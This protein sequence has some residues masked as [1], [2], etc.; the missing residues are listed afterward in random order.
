MNKTPENDPDL[1]T[2]R[3]TIDR[4]A[5]ATYSPE[6]TRRIMEAVKAEAGVRR[7]PRFY[8]FIAAALVLLVLLLVLPLFMP[9]AGEKPADP[10]LERLLAAQQADGFWLPDPP[11]PAAYA[12]G[13]TAL[14]LLRLNTGAEATRF[15]VE[16]AQRALLAIQ[17]PNGSFAGAY[18]HAL[19]TYALLIRH[20]GGDATL[21]A[22]LDR[23]LAAL[24]ET[25]LPEGSWGADPALT[26]WNGRT[27]N[28]AVLY[29][30]IADDAPAR[31]AHRW[32]ETAC[33]PVPSPEALLRNNAIGN[34][35]EF[36]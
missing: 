18:N 22:P 26:A 31:R 32:L 13:L 23:A 7:S 3:K 6:L 25:Q 20:T 9:K 30:L 1:E 36:R 2:L 14:A 24:I 34:R 11:A 17:Q 5:T 28:L 33:D 19:V 29:R 12:P 21:K 4:R 16:R 27:L 8:P 15:A 10:A 35:L